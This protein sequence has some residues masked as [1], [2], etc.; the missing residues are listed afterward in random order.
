MNLLGVGIYSVSQA[1]ALTKIPQHSIRRWLW[2]SGS[3]PLWD[4]QLGRIDGG[5]YLGFHDLTEMKFVQVLREKGL[6]LYRVRKAIAS[7]KARFGPYPFSSHQFKTDGL[8]VYVDVD[9]AAF[10]AESGQSVF[11]YLSRELIDVCFDYSREAGNIARW[12]PLGKEK[13]VVIDPARSFGRPIVDPGGVST[14]VLAQA[15]LVE[16]SEAWV[17]NIYEVPQDSV[18][19]AV[20]FER[21]LAA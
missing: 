11:E 2:G 7:L 5:L 19:A 3:I 21:S 20:E 18:H 17:A 6:S 8:R 16:G 1:A 12:W 9:P 10:E 13:E 15:V 14:E 4:P